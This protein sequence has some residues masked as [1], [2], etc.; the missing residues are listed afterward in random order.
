MPPAVGKPIGR[1]QVSNPTSEL[2]PNIQIWSSAIAFNFEKADW[3]REDN[4]GVQ[5]EGR[6]AEE[7]HHP[8]AGEFKIPQPIRLYLYFKSRFQNI[9]LLYWKYN[10]GEVQQIPRQADPKGEEGGHVPQ[11][12]S[13]RFG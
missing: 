3:E 13:P 6:R 9:K 11:T 1:L 2:N 5:R 10:P 4:P 7:G 8:P 12:P